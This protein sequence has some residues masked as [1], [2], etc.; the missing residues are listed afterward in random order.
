MDAD[1]GGVVKDAI[2]H[3]GGEHAVAGERAIPTAEGE[4]FHAVCPSVFEGW[5]ERAY[6]VMLGCHGA[7]ARIHRC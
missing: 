6:S 5:K 3:R 1:Y 4:I 7:G 2:E